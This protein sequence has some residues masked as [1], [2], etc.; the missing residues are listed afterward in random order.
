MN[1]LQLLRSTGLVAASSV[2]GFYLTAGTSKPSTDKK[3]TG[4]LRRLT[5]PGGGDNRSTF[6]PDNKTVVFA[7]E[8]SG[9]SQIWSVD[10]EGG[11]PKRFYESTSNDYGRVAPSPDGTRLCFSSDRESQN[12]I[13]VLG[14]RN[15]RVKR[16]SD[17]SYWSFGPTWSSRD[18]IA[19]FT[20]KGG[21]VLNIWSVRPDGSQSNQITNQPGESRQPWWSPDGTALAFCANN[22]SAIFAVWLSNADGRDARA[23]THH[24]TY[25]QPF[26]SPNGKMI[27]VSAKADEPYHR[28]YIMEADGSNL[29]PIDQPADVD[30]VHPA[31]SPDGRSVAFTSGNGASGS[32]FIFDFQA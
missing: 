11:V 29:M 27:A 25:A 21:N 5:E 19:F 20:K 9:M 32:I 17:L 10:R 16:I 15:R 8:R 24:G 26:W 1:R 31:W 14:I 18:E 2:L 22:T 28:I 6:L 4:Y 30:N 13:Y 23:I 7:S 3:I 12:A